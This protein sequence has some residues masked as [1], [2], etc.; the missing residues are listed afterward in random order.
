MQ[1][2]ENNRK[3]QV[4][5]LGAGFGG[6]YVA[7]EL[8]PY[9]R[10]GDIDVTIVNRTNYFLFTPLLH[11]VATGALSPNS[12]AEPLRGI[13]E[14]T[15][16]QVYQGEISHVDTASSLVKLGDCD[17][18]YDY[19]VV[20]TG[21]ETNY[22]GIKGADTIGLSLKNLADALKIRDRVIDAFE[23]A[24]VDH[25]KNRSSDALR[26]VVVGGGATGVE[27]AAELAEFLCEIR[28]RYYGKVDYFREQ[29]I[30]ITLVA[31]GGMLRQYHE[32]IQKVAEKRLRS[33][34]INVILDEVVSEV[35]SD[36]VIF[37]SGKTTAAGVVIWAA[38][39][40]PQLPVFKE[41]ANAPV[42]VSG[43]ITTDV[44]LRAVTSAPVHAPIFALGDSATISGQNVPMLAQVATAQAP[45]V[46]K[47]IIALVQN[48]SLVEYSPK[49][50]GTLVSLGQ[51]FAAGQAYRFSI[52][53]K[54]AWWIW[55]TVYLS[56]FAS[57]RKRIR[58]MFE[59]TIDLF[60]ARDITKTR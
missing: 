39:V 28:S 18:A 25:S 16:I 11:E 31:G 54:F 53:G 58:I 3:P 41:A 42:V 10:R 40:K 57:N 55:R 29:D 5:I 38:G 20:A 48:H 37:K 21:A 17:I 7:K 59:W 60:S 22:Y 26:F 14:D 19:L 6:V 50:K 47:N 52:Y 34:G 9:V 12:V 32:S 30:S 13:F 33:K 8:A 49:I 1:K 45:V 56:K 24:I 51:W 23:K 2:T 15:G 4:V 44:N 36:R 35:A 43:R 46:A 27:T